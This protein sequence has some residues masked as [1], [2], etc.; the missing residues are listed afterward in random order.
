[1]R[2]FLSKRDFGYNRRAEAVEAAR[3]EI[4]AA[5]AEVRDRNDLTDPKT[6]RWKEAVEAFNR[7]LDRVY[8]EPLRQIAIGNKSPL[9]IET[10]VILDFLEA[11]PIFFR[12][13]YM[14]EKL[15]TELKRRRLQ[16]RE[17]HRLQAIIL[18]VVTKNDFRREFRRY[19][20]VAPHVADEAFKADLLEI[21]HS[22]APNVSR[23]A[24]WVL[25][26]LRKV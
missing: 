26:A 24:N 8:A 9:E 22:S 13:G 1:M 2:S 3:A 16:E 21:Q 20:L 19:C 7:A 11:D 14:K 6:R 17:R 23:R 10:A 25:S 18:T 5:I 15:L 12:S 4:R